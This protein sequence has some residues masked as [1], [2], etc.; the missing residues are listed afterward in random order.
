MNMGSD[1]LASFHRKNHKFYHPSIDP[2]MGRWKL[3]SI[4]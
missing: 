4:P 1:V 2:G 3:G